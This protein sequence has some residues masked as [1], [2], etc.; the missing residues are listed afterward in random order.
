MRV[1]TLFLALALL[2]CGKANRQEV[3]LLA[4]LLAWRSG[5]HFADVGAGD[6]SYAVEAARAVGP[7]G[8]VYATEMD[9]G[10]LAH[11][12]QL[13]GQHANLRVIAARETETGLPEACCDSIL[14]RG[15]YHHITAPSQLDA[16]LYR[17]LKPGGRL[18]VIDF[19]P[20]KLVTWFFP[21][22]NVPSNRGGHGVPRDVVNQELRKAGFH[23]DREIPDW[24]G[25]QYCILARKQ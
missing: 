10:K 1:A 4:D 15:V 23:I 5:A 3:V 12:R 2:A 24:P 20:K 17:A 9:S 7:A 8:L 19:P 25:N 21:S 14:L 13:A 18:A 16:A 11:L 6:G 22:H